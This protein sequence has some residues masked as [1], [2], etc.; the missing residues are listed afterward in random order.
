MPKHVRTDSSDSKKINET[1]QDP[2][3]EKNDSQETAQESPAEKNTQTPSGSSAVIEAPLVSDQRETTNARSR[4]KPHL[5]IQQKKS[6]RMRK[7]LIVVLALIVALIGALA[8]FSFLLFQ[9]AQ[10]QASQQTLSQGVTD[11]DELKGEQAQDSASSAKKEIEAPD[12]ISVLGKT[13]DEALVIVER[14]ATLISATPVEEEGNPIKANLKV[15]LT[16]EPAASRSGTPTLYLDL[17]A[18]GHVISAGYS[19][20]ASSLGY[21]STSF[22]DAIQNKK[23]IE[24]TFEEAGLILPAG[25]VVLPEDKALYSTYATDATTLTN[26]QFSFTGT[27]EQGGI[28]YEWSAVLR[29]DYTAANSTGNLANTVRQ[30]YLYVSMPGVSVAAPVEDAPSE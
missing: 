15:S 29:Y 1:T 6:R 8:Y 21:G 19:A 14:G 7:V 17:D 10:T 16:D 18:Q 22:S 9:E 12:L 30:V 25:S 11:I 24:N 5:T 2:S 13:Q 4:Q 23:I 27:V 28:A 3:T 20:A 26:E